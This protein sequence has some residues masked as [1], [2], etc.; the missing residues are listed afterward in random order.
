[1]Q[2]VAVREKLH[3]MHQ[4]YLDDANTKPCAKLS[5]EDAE[6]ILTIKKK[7]ASLEVERC[8]KLLAKEDV[9]AIDKK[10]SKQKE[11]FSNCCHKEG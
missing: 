5:E 8:H 10:I 6:K 2:T 1:M 3:Q 7:L 4:K 11:L 9:T